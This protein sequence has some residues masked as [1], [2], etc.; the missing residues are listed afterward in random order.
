[1][2]RLSILFLCFV[3]NGFAMQRDAAYAKGRSK[4]APITVN[5]RAYNSELG[6][7]AKTFER[8][9][10][11]CAITKKATTRV[12]NQISAQDFVKHLTGD[13]ATA[14]YCALEES[15]FNRRLLAA[16]ESEIALRLITDKTFREQ[17]HK[18]HEE[19]AKT[20]KT[21]P[22]DAKPLTITLSL[23]NT[24]IEERAK[25]FGF[26]ADRFRAVATMFNLT[27]YVVD[28]VKDKTSARDFIQKLSGEQ[29]DQ[30]YTALV[31]TEF[32][33]ARLAMIEDA[34]ME[35]VHNDPIFCEQGRQAAAAIDAAN[36]GEQEPDAGATGLPTHEPDAKG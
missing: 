12:T 8:V 24:G 6:R 19:F 9:A 34:I 21:Y 23:P 15:D 30:L 29:A 1:M 31:K 14:V 3:A 18:A 5:F 25:M 16:I 20:L 7:P 13:Q 4:P 35:R 22:A 10:N 28:N 11:T 2:K 17:S 26:I 36:S 33:K 32:D 27:Q